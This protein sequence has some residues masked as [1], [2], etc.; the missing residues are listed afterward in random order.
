VQLSCP[1]CETLVEIEDDGEPTKRRPVRCS[2]CGE[3]WFTGGKTD[4]YALSFEKPNQVDPEVARIL[5][6]EADREMAARE[7]DKEARLNAATNS[8]EEDPSNSEVQSSNSAVKE[9]GYVTLNWR[10][11]VITLCLCL[12]GG[13]AAI[14]IFALDVARIFPALTDWVF[15]YV[16]WVNDM[17]HTANNAT[18]VLQRFLIDL[19]IAA[20]VGEVT[21]WLIDSVQ[22]LIKFLVNLVPDGLS[23]QK[24]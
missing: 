24:D 12:L 3:S 22:A 20:A 5:Q 17:R 14:Y 1:K 6:E 9:D 11:R 16:F 8:G 13:L 15:Y 4:L 18:E 2:S 10:Q 7:A 21:D 19:N 23:S